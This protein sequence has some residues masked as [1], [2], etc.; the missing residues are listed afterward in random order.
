MSLGLTNLTTVTL[1]DKY[2]KTT[3]T[4]KT[5][6]LPSHHNYP[7]HFALYSSVDQEGWVMLTQGLLTVNKNNIRLNLIQ[8]S[9]YNMIIMIKTQFP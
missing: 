9:N 8:I 6:F 2:L 4:T 1:R 5:I 3:K 7:K